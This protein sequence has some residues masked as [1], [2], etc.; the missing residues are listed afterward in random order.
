VKERGRK[1]FTRDEER[2]TFTGIKGMKGMGSK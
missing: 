1:D 2:K